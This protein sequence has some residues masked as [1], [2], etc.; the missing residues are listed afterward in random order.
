MELELKFNL[1]IWNNKYMKKLLKHLKKI[2][3]DNEETNKSLYP[4]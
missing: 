4:L 1:S 3:K 2:I